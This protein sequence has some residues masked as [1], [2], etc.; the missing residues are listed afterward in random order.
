MDYFY[1]L[2]PGVKYF[3]LLMIGLSVMF[4]SVRFVLK[5]AQSAWM[6]RKLLKVAPHVIDTLLLLS[7]VVLCF[8]IKQ[9]PFVDA[10]MTEK[11]GAVVA[12]IVLAIAAMNSARG[13]TFRIF[14][15]LGA[16][17]WLVFAAKVAYVKQAV[18]FG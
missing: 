17:G 16:L 6:E 7:G 15:F 4:L 2:Y 10:W 14:A 1:S 9:Y 18:F 13:K 12:Y 11:L 8:M 5:L 3:H